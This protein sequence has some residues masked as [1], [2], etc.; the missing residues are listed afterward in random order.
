LNL[1]ANIQFNFVAVQQMAAEGQSD[2]KVRL[3]QRC[4]IKFL[5]AEKI[6]P[7]DIHR[8]LLDVYGDQTVDVRLG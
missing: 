8:C 1:P 6:A 2:K 7:N 5:H 3:K 4:V